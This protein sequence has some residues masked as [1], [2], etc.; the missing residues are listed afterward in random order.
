M[1]RSIFLA[2]QKWRDHFWLLKHITLEQ[3]AK[4][5]RNLCS[6][7]ASED[8]RTMTQRVS[9]IRKATSTQATNHQV[10]RNKWGNLFKHGI[11][12][13]DESVK[14]MLLKASNR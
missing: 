8:A 5:E 14:L 11:R 2:K 4:T 12:D 1:D 3:P 6:Q 7:N 10:R 13:K 9:S